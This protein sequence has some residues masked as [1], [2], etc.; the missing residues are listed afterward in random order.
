MTNTQRETALHDAIMNLIRA[1]LDSVA[2][3]TS[4]SDLASYQLLNRIMHAASTNLTAALSFN[5]PDH[6]YYFSD[7]VYDEICAPTQ[8]ISLAQT[9][10]TELFDVD[11]ISDALISAFDDLITD[12]LLDLD[13]MIDDDEYLPTSIDDLISLYADDNPD[14]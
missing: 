14:D 5:T 8:T 6:P 12:V 7:S 1:D 11:V 4:L 3:L 10:L 2:D 13:D 9:V